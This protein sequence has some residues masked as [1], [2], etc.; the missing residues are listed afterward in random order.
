MPS[1]KDIFDTRIPEVLKKFPEKAREINASYC[2]KVSG[3]GG[4]EW[5][6]DLL[7][8]PP[9]CKPGVVL[10]GRTVVGEGAILEAGCVLRDVIVGA[11]A[12][13]GAHAVLTSQTVAPG[14]T[15]AP[16]SRLTPS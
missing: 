7:S 16:F 15:V 2:M 1:A 11:G 14:A 5:V 3:D 4:G 10:A 13:I 12:R 9:I 6:V 8:D